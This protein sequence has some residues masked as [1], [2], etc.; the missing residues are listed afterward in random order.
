MIKIS[1][2]SEQIDK[3]DNPDRSNRSHATVATTMTPKEAVRRFHNRIS[4]AKIKIQIV[5]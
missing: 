3:N 5:K 4:A 1:N 2:T